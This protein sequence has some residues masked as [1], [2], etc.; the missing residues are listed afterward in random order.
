MAGYGLG[1]DRSSPTPPGLLFFAY[2]TPFIIVVGILGNV[3]SLFVFRHRALRRLSASL[4]LTAICMSDS[5]VLLTYVLWDWLNKGLPHWPGGH[6]LPLVNAPGLCE[7]FLFPSYV[8]RLVSVWLIVT[9]TV[10]RYVA[11]CHPLQRRLICT[12]S[13]SVKLIG[14]VCCVAA[15]LC[16][17]KPALNHAQTVN[18]FYICSS[19]PGF[20]DAN[21]VLDS[22]YG[23]S[24]TALPFAIITLLN[25]LILRKLV[26]C[27]KSELLESRA[28]STESRMRLE[29]TV[30]LLTISF[31]FICLNIPYFA[32]WC[33]RFQTIDGLRSG[34]PSDGAAGNVSSLQ[35]MLT[36]QQDSSNRDKFLVARTIFYLNY[37]VNFFLYCVTG[38]Q[39]R[40]HVMQLFRC[41]GDNGGSRDAR[42]SGYTMYSFV[43][44]DK[45]GHASTAL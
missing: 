8:F 37:A 42:R 17:Y 34:R 40:K 11:V 32:V 5:F 41:R 10:E 26:C 18:G 27:R 16:T 23:V 36:S 19:R 30:I 6:R 14:T 15:V 1:G 38:K 43:Q 9:F 29:F 45:N 3:A 33:K 39:Y 35:D 24:I 4:Y 31:C 2:L 28:F 12:R 7:A 25:T 21:W 20:E 22:I 13:F 44:L